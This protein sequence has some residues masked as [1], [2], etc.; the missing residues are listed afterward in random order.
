MKRTLA[1]VA[2]SVAL[3]AAGLSP[4]WAATGPVQTNPA[5]WTPQMVAPSGGGYVRQL[6]PCGTNMYAVGTFSQFTSPADGGVTFTRNNALS[7]RGSTGKVTPFNPNTNGVVNSIALNPADCSTAWI[8]GSFTTVG[9]QPASNLAAVD[10]TT[11]ALK[12]TFGHSANNRVNALL[13]THGE[14]LAGGNF[15]TINGAARS[16]LAS[17]NPTT[18]APDGYLVL[19][20]TGI[21]PGTSGATQSYNFTL[22]HSG[23]QALVTGIFTAVGGAHREQVFQLNLGIS[24]ATLSPWTSTD[25][26]RHCAD[27][28]PFYLQDAAY[29]P[30]DSRIYTAATGYKAPTDPLHTGVCD[31]AAAY[32]NTAGQVRSQWVNYTGCDSL[33]AVVADT[34]TVY[35]AGHQR[36]LD[37]ETSCD[38]AGLTSASRPGLGGIDPTTGRATT[39]NPT[40]SR[41]AGA[42]DLVLAFNGLWIA[43]DDHYSS[44]RCGGEYHPGICFLPY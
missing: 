11:G 33:Y 29:A 18:G 14:L 3:L 37:N 43:S 23:N 41:G 26:Y 42:D 10:S 9:G 2:S 22:S 25:F 28:L 44:T 27:G 19:P 1:T 20:L 30:D 31:A 34:S 39:W 7:F 36:Y 5:D 13:Y 12:A 40:R 8:G 35:V 21:Y 24:G 15:T 32:P 17:L 6:T 4:A 38:R 16:R